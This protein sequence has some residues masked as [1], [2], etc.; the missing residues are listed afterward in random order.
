MATKDAHIIPSIVSSYMDKFGCNHAQFL[1]TNEDG[2]VYSLSSL[3]EYGNVL[4]IGLPILII[5]KDNEASV[6]DGI[7]ALKYQDSLTLED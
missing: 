6:L 4:P 3:D 2:D 5:V 1:A 7:K